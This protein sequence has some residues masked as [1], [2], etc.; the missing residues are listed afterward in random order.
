MSDGLYVV[1]DNEVAGLVTRLNN[2]RLRFDY[3]DEYRRKINSTPLSVSMPLQ[4][5]SHPDSVISPWLSGLLPDNEAVI[6]R[7]ARYYQ[8][9]ASSAFSLLSTPIGHDV[10]G[11]FRF[12]TPEALDEVRE[13][14]GHVTWLNEDELARQLSELKA[15]TTS[16]LGRYFQGHFSLAGAQAKTALLFAN[17]KWGVPTGSIPTTHILKPAVSGFDGHDI[18]EHLCLDA[19]RRAGLV[20]SRSQIMSFGDESVLV[21]ERYDRRVVNGE[22]VRIH[23]EDLCQAL[24]VWPSYKYQ[25]DGGP[26]PKDIVHLFRQV[27]STRS[28]E[29]AIERFVGALAWNWIIGGTDGH[30]KNYSLVLS[31]GDI[32]LAPLYDIA[33]ALPYGT[34]ERKLRLA[35]KVGDE[36]LVA[37]MR[38]LWPK[39]A[40]DLD[41]DPDLTIERVVE[42]VRRAPDAMTDAARAI[43]DLSLNHALTPHLVDLVSERARRCLRILGN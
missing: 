24:S 2:G 14:N 27:M 22:I 21:I 17:G 9:G 39:V 41:L 8:V 3:D 16:W 29:D 43:G 36:Y 34:H 11:A 40:D 38:N 1:Y 15:D 20:V 25:S 18:N 26:G 32:R 5:Q 10:A 31:Q 30:A 6:A 19:A 33:S 13:R 42:L 7:W 28:K 23:Q 35:M 12:A 4:V 37:P